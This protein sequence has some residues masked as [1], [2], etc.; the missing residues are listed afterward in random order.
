MGFRRRT[1]LN[2][3]ITII[4]ITI[5]EVTVRIT[6][7]NGR[8]IRSLQIILVRC[9]ILLL[10]ASGS[11]QISSRIVHKMTLEKEIKNSIQREIMLIIHNYRRIL[12]ITMIKSQ[13]QTLTASTSG[14]VRIQMDKNI[15]DHRPNHRLLISNKVC[16]N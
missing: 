15:L 7:N 1:T 14:L 12:L 8:I 3:R 11:Q 6:L 5:N 13:A 9:T 16:H 4:I 10:G 2:L